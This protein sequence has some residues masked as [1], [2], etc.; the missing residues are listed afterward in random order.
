MG[1]KK[2]DGQKKFNKSHR[3]TQLKINETDKTRQRAQR[4]R[5]LWTKESDKRW[6][7]TAVRQTAGR[8]KSNK[9]QKD[10][11]L[12]INGTEEDR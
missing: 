6:I 3:K 10:K 2:R 11:Q 12:R 8:N 4:D 5:Q 9:S 7:E 1:M